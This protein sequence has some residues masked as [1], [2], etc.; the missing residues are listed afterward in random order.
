MTLALMVPVKD[1]DRAKTR[2][3]PLLAAAE[4]RALAAIMLEGTLRAGEGLEGVGRRVVVT[5]YRPAMELAGLHGFE[6]L[7]EEGQRSESDSVDAACAALER[8]GVTA[9]LRVPLDL[10]LLRGE[11]LAAIVQAAR[12]GAQVV[13]VPSLDGTG[14]NALYRSPP[15]RFPS[16]FGSGSLALHMEESRRSGAEPR[17]LRLES[18]ALDIDDEADLRELAR[19][20]APCAALDYLRSIGIT[21]RLEARK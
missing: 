4:R 17:V 15:G 2:L 9:I 21:E 12:Q 3:A 19:R 7:R 13:L 8:E 20:A 11:D 5:S 6:V 18:L 14:T 1:L 10:P 16:R